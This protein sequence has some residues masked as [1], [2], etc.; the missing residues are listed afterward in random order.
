MATILHDP[1]P[2]L[3]TMIPTVWV[4]QVMQGFVPSTVPLADPNESKTLLPVQDPFAHANQLRAV[5]L[6]LDTSMH[7]QAR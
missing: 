7:T 3:S 5:F 2:A 4:Y 6:V 1:K